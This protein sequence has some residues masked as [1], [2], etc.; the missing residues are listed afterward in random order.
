M[1][2]K[3]LVLAVIL[4]STSS[5]AQS[6]DSV[7]HRLN[8]C[9]KWDHYFGGFAALPPTPATGNVHV[10]FF[11]DAQDAANHTV[12]TASYK[13]DV[14]KFSGRCNVTADTLGGYNL[15]SCPLFDSVGIVGSPP[16][17][18]NFQSDTLL[19]PQ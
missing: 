2:I 14:L 9:W 16:V 10:E 11:Q 12:S 7:I 15:L 1:R 19:F 4:A 8:G 17:F 5:F 13:D 18:F 3:L 6:V